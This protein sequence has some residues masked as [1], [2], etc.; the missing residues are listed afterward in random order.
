M[1]FINQRKSDCEEIYPESWKNIFG[2][3]EE[4]YVVRTSGSMLR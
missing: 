4:I 3:T 2:A 1:M